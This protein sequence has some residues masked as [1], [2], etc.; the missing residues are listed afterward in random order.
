MPIDALV[1]NGFA[2]LRRLLDPQDAQRLQDACNGLLSR[3]ALSRAEIGTYRTAAAW[4]FGVYHDADATIAV[5]VLGADAYFDA[6][7]E[8]VVT[9][10]TVKAALTAAL[11]EG[12]KLQ[13]VNIRRGESGG[14]GLSIHQDTTGE[15]GLTVLMSEVTE[16][17]TTVFLPGSHR[18]PITIREAFVYPRISLGFFPGSSLKA[19]QGVPGEAY[20]FFNRTW[21]GRSPSDRQVTA[22][23]SSF[24]PAGATFR[25][26]EA[27]DE[28][29]NKLGPEL[30]KLLDPRSGVTAVGEGYVRV[31]GTASGRAPRWRD[32]LQAILTGD[33]G[34]SLP[35]SWKMA[36]AWS[37]ATG[38]LT[39]LA[40]GARKRALAM[41][42]H[43]SHSK[44]A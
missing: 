20:L 4:K 19:A 30:R 1:Q 6:A 12:Y 3:P 38:A 39:P 17:G 26:H 44:H 9:H 41:V 28:I 43:R 7:F 34:N 25:I 23:M 13:Q 16:S 22:I 27:P 35:P 24:Y 36:R 37:R 31:L 29:L 15:T 42:S 14:R 11:G 18:W 32:D 10:P 21:H 8:R 2:P 33:F 40:A 5:D